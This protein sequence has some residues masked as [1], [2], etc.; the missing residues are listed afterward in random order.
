[1]AIKDDLVQQLMELEADI[2]EAKK[3]LEEGRGQHAW[4][5]SRYRDGISAKLDAIY[6]EQAPAVVARLQQQRDELVGQIENMPDDD[7]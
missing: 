6:S 3:R 2:L 5:G 1:M 4:L 7:E